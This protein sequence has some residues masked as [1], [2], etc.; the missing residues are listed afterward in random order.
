MAAKTPGSPD[1]PSENRSPGAALSLKTAS[2]GGGNTPDG[3]VG[4]DHPC[5][6]WDA[7]ATV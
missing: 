6:P 1:M 7:A 5:D 2:A 3:K 4:S